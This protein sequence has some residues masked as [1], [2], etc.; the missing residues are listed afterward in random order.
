MTPQTV[1]NPASVPRLRPGA[2]YSFRG[3]GRTITQICEEL[4]IPVKHFSRSLGRGRR[5]GLF[6]KDLVEWAIMMQSRSHD[7]R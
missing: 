7:S 6:G 4:G 5:A 1:E 3:R 2:K